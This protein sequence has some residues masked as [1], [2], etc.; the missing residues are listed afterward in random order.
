[1][2]VGILFSYWCFSPFFLPCTYCYAIYMLFKWISYPW[3]WDFPVL[4]C[5]YLTYFGRSFNDKPLN[6]DVNGP[7]LG[8]ELFIREQ[9]DLLS[10]LKDIPKKAC[11]RKVSFFFNLIFQSW[12]YFPLKYDMCMLAKFFDEIN[13]W[14][15]L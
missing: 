3:L 5:D 1:M 12:L 4:F 9:E 2:R 14:N 10:D 7:L 6:D 15:K 13:L 8:N 11:D